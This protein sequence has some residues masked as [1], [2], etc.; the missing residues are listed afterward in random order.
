MNL[1]TLIILFIKFLFI[2]FYYKIE[3]FVISISKKYDKKGKKLLDIGAGNSPYKKYFKK[4]SYFT[5]DIKQNQNKTIDYIGN[6]DKGL[7]M[8]KK[9]S[10][11]YIL[12]TQVLE[13]L[14]NPQKTFQEFYRILKPKG[15]VFLTTNFIYQIHMIP[16]DYYRF[17]KYGL[18]YLGKSNGFTI[19][20]LKPHGGIFHVAS[21]ILT[22]LP[23]R[24]FLKR[25]VFL[26][27]LYL[28]LFSPLIIFFNLS[29]HVLD[30]FDTEKELTINYEAI[31]RKI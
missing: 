13:H 17:T 30:F 11:D 19:E 7:K 26:Y 14:K 8:I 15:K 21:Y 24:L 2:N 1:K 3:K 4:L 22:T 5:Q 23:I 16:N 29:A 10:F 20:H 31:Y 25:K 18:E 12:C 28:I 9:E 6:L 27:H